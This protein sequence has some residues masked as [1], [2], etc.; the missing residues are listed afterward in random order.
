[1]KSPWR[2][3]LAAWV[4]I[5]AGAFIAHLTQT[6]GGITIK[7]VRFNGAAGKTLSALLYL[8]PTATPQ[9]KA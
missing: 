6:A 3:F 9:T 8:P 1:M 5:L 4:I 2:V 7:D